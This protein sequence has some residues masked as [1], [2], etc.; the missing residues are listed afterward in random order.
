MLSCE[1]A[2]PLMRPLAV[3]SNRQRAGIVAATDNQGNSSL[4]SDNII[5]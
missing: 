2:F 4:M 3:A 5:D 1:T